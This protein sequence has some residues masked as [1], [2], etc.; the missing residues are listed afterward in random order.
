ML[1]VVFSVNGVEFSAGQADTCRCC[2]VEV[3][4]KFVM[5]IIWERGET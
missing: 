4:E 2:D 3:A 5:V 1:A